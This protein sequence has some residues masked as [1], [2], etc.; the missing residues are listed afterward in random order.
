[1]NY[2]RVTILDRYIITKLPIA[3]NDYWQ[4][5]VEYFN[6]H[7]LPIFEDAPIGQFERVIDLGKILFE[8]N[9]VK[10]IKSNL[11]RLSLKIDLIDS[12]KG[13]LFQLVC[14]ESS[15]GVR[16][17]TNGLTVVYLVYPIVEC[18]GE[19]FDLHTIKFEIE[20]I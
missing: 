6:P 7:T 2:L 3:D 17:K 1:M 5:F 12:K 20:E 9:L 11:D 4:E 16:L 10:E 13:F 18:Q 14:K 19:K 15:G 8:K